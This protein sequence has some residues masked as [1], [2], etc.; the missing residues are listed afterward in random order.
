MLFQK[1]KDQLSIAGAVYSVLQNRTDIALTFSENPINPSATLM[2]GNIGVPISGL[3]SSER[4]QW[5]KNLDTNQETVKSTTII[6]NISH[7]KAWAEHIR[8]AQF[9]KATPQPVEVE[10]TP[11]DE[12]KNDVE[13]KKAD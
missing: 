12:S 1:H 13:N 2:A 11:A 4:P 8:R 6:R 9:F 10:Q 7:R 3:S 5:P